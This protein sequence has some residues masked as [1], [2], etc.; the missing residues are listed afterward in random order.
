[1][2]CMNDEKDNKD[3]VS[4]LGVRRQWVGIALELIFL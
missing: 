3:W 2:L 4:F 1:M